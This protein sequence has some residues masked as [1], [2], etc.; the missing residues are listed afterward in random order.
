MPG[1]LVLIAVMTNS[2]GRVMTR[3]LRLELVNAERGKEL[4]EADAV[5]REACAVFAE[6]DDVGGPEA[7]MERGGGL[8]WLMPWG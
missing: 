2:V 8:T 4:P 6:T 1:R 7:K 5:L 3:R